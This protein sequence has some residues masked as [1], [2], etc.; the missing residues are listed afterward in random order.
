MLY[1]NLAIKV[2][3]TLA[4]GIG[5]TFRPLMMRWEA[6]QTALAQA[7]AMR[8]TQIA[9]ERLKQDLQLVRSGELKIT[10]DFKL[11]EAASAADQEAVL[12]REYRES[13]L[14]SLRDTRT[15]YQQ[16]VE[17]ERQMNLDQIAVMAVE[18]AQE[19]EESEFDQKPIDSDWFA[20]WRNRAQ[21]VSNEQMQRLWAKI[22]A[23]Q[24][25]EDD[26]F[27]IHTLDFL[28]RMSRQEAELIE[29]LGSI[30]FRN[31]FIFADSPNAEYF[32]EFLSYGQLLMLDE[33]AVVNGVIGIPG[34]ISRTLNGTRQ[35]DGSL[36]AMIETDGKVM[37]FHLKDQKESLRIPTIHITRIGKQLLKLANVP[38]RR[39]AFEALAEYAKG[40]CSKIVLADLTSKS[41]DQYSFANASILWDEG[42]GEA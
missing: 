25:K 1:E 23:G 7:D 36:V 42:A 34:Q 5:T 9:Q 32:L 31:E 40:E 35:N 19:Q 29:K 14:Q 33:L 8:I 17:V 15:P 24:A 30:A 41:G 39:S 18:E 12:I 38:V 6:R 4:N 10:S 37:F 26:A 11:I 13:Y 27:S 3:E 2:F 28:S 16:I 20:Q 22:L 21:D